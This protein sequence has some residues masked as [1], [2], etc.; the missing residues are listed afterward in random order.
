[1]NQLAIFYKRFSDISVRIAILKNLESVKEAKQPKRYFLAKS[2]LYVVI[3]D[4]AVRDVGNL[5]ELLALTT[6]FERPFS[7]HEEIPSSGKDQKMS[8][9]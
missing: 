2:D 5:P 7:V 3:H 6:D 9:L 8:E 1:M 4:K